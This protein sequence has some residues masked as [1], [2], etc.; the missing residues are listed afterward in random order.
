MADLFLNKKTK[1]N[2]GHPNAGAAIGLFGYVAFSR[3][4]GTR[5]SVKE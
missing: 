1:R 5:F 2:E 4:Q 3:M